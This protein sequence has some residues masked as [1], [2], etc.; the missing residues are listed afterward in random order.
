MKLIVSNLVF[1]R[2]WSFKFGN[3][4]AS[5]SRELGTIMVEEFE[6]QVV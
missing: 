1:A 4:S 3:Y 6:C 5:R 2:D